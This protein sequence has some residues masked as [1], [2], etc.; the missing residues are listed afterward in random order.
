MTTIPSQISAEGL[1]KILL[2]QSMANQLPDEK[3]ILDFVCR[4]LEDMPGA[5]HAYVNN[6]HSPDHDHTSEAAQYRFPVQLQGNKFAEV[7]VEID[8][9]ELFLPYVSYIQNLCFTIAVMM[10]ERWL[11]RANEQHHQELELRVEERTRQLTEQVRE[12]EAAEKRAVAEKVRAERYL[13]VAD[14]FTLELDPQ[15]RIEIIN[16]WGSEILGYPP[17]ELIGRNWIDVAIPPEH[18]EAVRG[19]LHEI[20]SG[21]LAPLEYV[22]NEIVTR[23]GERR[24]IAWHN[25]LR[26]TEDGQILGTLSFGLDITERKA[27]EGLLR[28][29]QNDLDHAQAVA[30][31]GSW[32]LNMHRQE[33]V[34]SDEV[35]RIFGIET[36][37]S[38]TYEMFLSFVHP[39]D[40]AFVD[41]EWAAAL[42][43]K[44][45]DIDHR[46]MVNGAIK[47]VREKAELE[48][49][50]K[51]KL[52]GGFGT[53]QDITDRKQ[54]EFDLLDAKRAAEEASRAKS[55]FLTNMSHEL[56]TPLT[57]I[58]GSLGLLQRSVSA[59]EEQELVDFAA[60][61]AD[62]LLGIIDDLLDIS[63]IETGR[64]KI[65]ERPFDIRD[66]VRQAV[67]MFAKQGE[68]KGVRLHWEVTPQIPPQVRGDPDRLGQV[69]INLIGNAVKFTERGEVVVTVVRAGDE[70]LFS[71]RDTG[72]GIPADQ[73]SRL[74]QPFTQVDGSHTR[75]YGGTGLGLVIS[76]ELLLLMGGSIRLESE[77]GQG[78]TVTFTL[79][80]RPAENLEEVT[81]S[82]SG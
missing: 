40:R 57:V 47:W 15:G 46:I 43:G 77:E 17:Q 13:D 68:E 63:R 60:T 19:I 81:A 30:H 69:L 54:L 66:C 41:T 58:M 80:L 2:I 55:Q 14:A 75:P 25:A 70:L 20:A 62:L 3:A 50:E 38:M 16:T 8:T 45:Y 12:R 7:V 44:P 48:F 72:I 65:E 37:T 36:G 67:T 76:K 79:P 28:M 29:K 27:A 49:D 23:E 42:N 6:G 4:G 53:V 5:G 35:Y 51:G 64:L 74:F 31:M 78:S 24:L 11:R 52:L 73:I 71:V 39:E 32:R 82:R 18:R 61:S 22:E 21:N 56:R 26:L 59:P 9:P 33:L 1:A 34:W 10:E